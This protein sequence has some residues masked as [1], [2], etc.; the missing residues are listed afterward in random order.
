MRKNKLLIMVVLLSC[1]GI[2]GIAYGVSINIIGKEGKEPWNVLDKSYISLQN[3]LLIEDK[4][5]E[6][7][8]KLQTD[9]TANEGTEKSRQIAREL[10]IGKYEFLPASNSI[11]KISS[12]DQSV[13]VD[14]NEFTFTRFEGTTQRAIQA[15]P[16]SGSPWILASAKGN[17][18]VFP[19]NQSI[20]SVAPDTLA[21]NKITSDTAFG[22]PVQQ[23]FTE[24]RNQIFW[25]ADPALSPGGEY[26]TYFSTKYV[27]NGKITPS[28]GIWLYSFKDRSEKLLFHNSDFEQGWAVKSQTM[29]IDDQTFV[30]AAYSPDNKHTY[31]KYHL[32]TMQKERILEHSAS[33][34]LSKGYL[35]FRTSPEVITVLDLK[36]DL[37]N[38]FALPPLGNEYMYSFSNNGRLAIPN[39]T[40]IAILD[41]K[42]ASITRYALPDPNAAFT[43]MD[44]IDDNVLLINKEDSS[45]WTL[46][47][48]G[49]KGE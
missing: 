34:E 19:H 36:T 33:V 27:D 17:Q 28:D 18:F 49:G 42:D 3:G 11:K 15:S 40:H 7:T 5:K 39:G 1:L 20:Y 46:T 23:Y 10:D 14:G 2:S 48:Q 25:A 43:I 12:F 45:S 30:F 6:Y 13:S 22:I 26:M 9:K 29:W 47:H 21:V 37:K 35:F 24:G 44:W 8:E 38:E 16:F 4:T 41:T 32:D 31:Y